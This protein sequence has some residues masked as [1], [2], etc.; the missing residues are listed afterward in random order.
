M[1]EW[2]KMFGR[3]FLKDFPKEEH[4]KILREV[5]AELQD[6]RYAL[7]DLAKLP[8]PWHVRYNRFSLYADKARL[9]HLQLIKEKKSLG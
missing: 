9:S 7:F 2:L 1:F 4:E 5:N 3:P 6:P 8:N